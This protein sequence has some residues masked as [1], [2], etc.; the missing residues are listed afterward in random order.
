MHSIETYTT[1]QSINLSAEVALAIWAT[2]ELGRTVR[3]VGSSRR[4]ESPRRS[5]SL[6]CG[7]LKSSLGS[8]GPA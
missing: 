1:A 7:V 2:Y 3:G 8:R 4:V 5:I 6:C